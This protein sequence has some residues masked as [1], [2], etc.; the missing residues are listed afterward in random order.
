MNFD[1]NI[2]ATI[3]LIIGTTNFLLAILLM[4]KNGKVFKWQSIIMLFTSIWSIA[5][6]FEL[7]SVSLNQILFF[8]N[9]EFFGISFLPSLWIIFVFYFTN[10]N[11]WLT[12]INFIKLLVFPIVNI[13][14]VISNGYH[15]FYYQFVS[16]DF[17]GDFPL[18][19]A[20]PGSAY[21]IFGVYFYFMLLWGIFLLIKSLKNNYLK[22]KFQTVFLVIIILV[23]LLLNMFYTLGFKPFGNIDINVFVLTFTTI[24]SVF[25]LLRI[26]ISNALPYVK[27][28]YIKNMNDGVIIT[29]L[30]SIILETNSKI[31]KIFN[32]NNNELIGSNFLQTIGNNIDFENAL[33]NNENNVSTLINDYLFDIN[34]SKNEI[35]GIYLIILKEIKSSDNNEKSEK[36]IKELEDINNLK[37]KLFS[38]IAHDLKSP[39]ANLV[40]MLRMVNEDKMLVD[41]FKV[42]LPKLLESVEYNSTMIENLLNWSRSQIDS[43]KIVLENIVFKNLV[44]SEIGFFINKASEKNIKIINEVKENHHIFFDKNAIQLVIRNLLSNAIKFCNSGDVI[45]ISFEEFENRYTIIFADTGIGMSNENVNKLFGSETISTFGTNNEKGTGIGLLLC[46][47]FIEKSGGEIHVESEQGKGTTFYI[48]LPKN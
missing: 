28:N 35:V 22:Q 10:K 31:N 38:I 12:R 11:E 13:G 42:F 5:Y 16:L 39:F 17:S 2:F 41:E 47:D 23:L 15:S 1:F 9:I 8:L 45:T 21:Y 30:N 43:V 26:N 6:A 36:H 46:K 29:D 7:A 33:A 20:K 25:V 40:S 32:K 14:L 34:I 24:F 3:L 27:D 48:F 19:I 44:D 37:D 4:S 18:L